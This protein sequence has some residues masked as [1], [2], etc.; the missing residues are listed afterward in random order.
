MKGK[1]DL[2]DIANWHLLEATPFVGVKN[3]K[4]HRQVCGRGWWW[5]STCAMIGFFHV[6][7]NSFSCTSKTKWK[8]CIHY[9]NFEIMYVIVCFIDGEI[10]SIIKCSGSP[11]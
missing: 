3:A 4:M 1:L 2:E 10:S 7:S 5:A 11:Q 8:F 9:M 6:L